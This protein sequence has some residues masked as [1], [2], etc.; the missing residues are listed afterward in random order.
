ML[1]DPRVNFA[2]SSRHDGGVRHLGNQ[3]ETEAELAEVY[4]R[5]RAADGPV[6]EEAGEA[7][8]Y[9]GGVDAAAPESH[10]AT[11]PPPCCEPGAA[12]IEAK[13]PKS[14]ACCEPAC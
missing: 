6:L 14:A 9:G 12:A 2:I 13:T 1:E 10:A 4:D 3:V 5:L 8:T 11:K 7:T